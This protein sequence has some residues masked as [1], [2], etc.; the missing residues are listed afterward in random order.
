MKKL[1]NEHI[2]AFPHESGL[3][4]LGYP[5]NGSGRISD[6]LSYKQWFEMN[7]GQRIHLNYVEHLPMIIGFSLIAG[8]LYPCL[9]ASL[10]F[11]Y[12]IGRIIYA[13]GYKI[14]PIL[15]VPGALLMDV[16]LLVI[17]GYAVYSIYLFGSTSL[18]AVFA[19]LFACLAFGFVFI[20]PK[21]RAY[22]TQ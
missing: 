3:P 18:A 1:K 21:R 9:I 22:F 20:F 2:Q 13:E 19:I 15:R 8:V 10:G 5:D 16:F 11:L 7:Q 6:T 17:I 12:V 4:A 14:R